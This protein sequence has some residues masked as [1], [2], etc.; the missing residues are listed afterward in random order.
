[1]LMVKKDFVLIRDYVTMTLVNLCFSVEGN[2][3]MELDEVS[4]SDK[5]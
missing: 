3:L 1:M 4:Y 5:R 2:F